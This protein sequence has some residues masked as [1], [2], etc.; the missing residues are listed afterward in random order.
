MLGRIYLPDGAGTGV[1]K[2]EFLVSG[3][4][5]GPD[6]EIGTAVTAETS[7]GDLIGTVVDMRTVGTSKDPVSQ[8]VAQRTAD[9]HDGPSIRETKSAKVATVQ[10]FHSPK[11]RSP[12]DGV[13]RP[14]TPEEIQRATGADRNKWPVA[15]GVVE[16]I[17]GELA[18]VSLDGTNLAGPEGAHLAIGGLSGVAAKSSFACVMLR[19]LLAA[20]DRDGRRAGAIIF[21]IKGDDLLHMDQPP[22]EGY[23]LDDTD[24]AIYEAMGVPPTPFDGV[25][26]YAPAMPAGADGVQSRRGDALRLRWSLRDVWPY[27]RHIAP[28]LWGN[29]NS[30]LFLDDF[31]DEKLNHTSKHARIDTFAKLHAWFDDIN[32]RKSHDPDDPDYNVRE[33]KWKSHHPATLNKMKKRLL[34]LQKMFGG[35]I[36]DGESNA[37]DDVPTTGWPA[38][39]VIVVDI[40]RMDDKIKA[41]V[42]ARV[43]ERL[44]ESAQ[45]GTL[46][47]D[48]LVV[49]A[50]EL[51]RFAPKDATGDLAVVRKT[52]QTITT[53]GR[54]FGM[55][56]WGMAQMLSKVDDLVRDNSATRALGISPDAELSSGVHGRLERGV[57]EQIATMDRGYMCV[58]HYAT[59]RAPMVIRFP[60]PPC[61]M[62][63]PKDATSSRAPQRTDVLQMSDGQRK[64]LTAGI[65]DDVVDHVVSSSATVDEARDK[66]DRMRTPDPRAEQLHEP[67]TPSPD[68]P[69]NIDV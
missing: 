21:N 27:L 44:Y 42:V 15:A 61:Q 47:L 29:E 18:P 65:P 45:N 13:V 23:E 31:R 68:N 4:G 63:A 40:S 2:Y 53:Q 66:L 37:A 32:E 6:V 8:A 62:Q 49:W 16:L 24:R 20:A 55:S 41:L 1:G 51:N 60:R 28:D 26:V 33:L 64:G 7:E 50:D 48:S 57:S 38:G 59:L 11:L 34:G 30:R 56:L 19:S 52:F 54:A 5:D 39:Q 22:S 69:Y 58:W 25:R 43:C 12:S 35:L 10:V 36:C 17:G 3:N 67:S 14:A 46:G 9:R